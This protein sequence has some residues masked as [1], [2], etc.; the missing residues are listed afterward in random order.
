M[1]MSPKEGL[2]RGRV[3]KISKYY[4]LFP[5]QTFPVVV[6]FS[7]FEISKYYRLSPHQSFPV[8]LFFY[9]FKISKYYR[10]TDY[11]PSLS[12]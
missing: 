2:L 12:L 8:V 9:V 7:V 5:H 4:R 10:V 6:F 3:F 1:Y 11:P